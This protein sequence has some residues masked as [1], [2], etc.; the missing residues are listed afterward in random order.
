MVEFGG[1]SGVST[2]VPLSVLTVPAGGGPSLGNRPRVFADGSARRVRR[3]TTGPYYQPSEQ[4]ERQE[5]K[6]KKRVEE[7][8]HAYWACR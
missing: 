3:V 7:N 6:N 2:Q 5:Q 4:R 1:K 8:S